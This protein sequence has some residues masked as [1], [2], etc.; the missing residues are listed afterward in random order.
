MRL[1]NVP[2]VYHISAQNIA[3]IWEPRS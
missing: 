1:N 3:A 2:N